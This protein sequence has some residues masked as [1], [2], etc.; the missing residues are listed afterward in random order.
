MLVLSLSVLV[1]VIC[2]ETPHPTKFHSAGLILNG[3]SIV[4]SVKLTGQHDRLHTVV[5][6]E[7]PHEEARQVQRVYELAQGLAA[8]HH[9]ERRV[10]CGTMALMSTV[11]HYE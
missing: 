7:H 6:P 1:H 11:A 2:I 3:Q 8:A 4:R 9:C 5:V 10:A